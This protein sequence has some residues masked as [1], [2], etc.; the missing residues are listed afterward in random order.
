MSM[1]KAAACHHIKPPK[2]PPRSKTMRANKKGKCYTKH[3]PT[4]KDALFQPGSITA[5][6]ISVPFNSSSGPTRNIKKCQN[7][8]YL[9]SWAP[10]LRFVSYSS[11]SFLRNPSSTKPC[12]RSATWS[13]SSFSSP[14]TSRREEKPE[15]RS[16]LSE[17]Q[18]H[19]GM[20]GDAPQRRGLPRWTTGGSSTSR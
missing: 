12:Q 7:Y 15:D 10:P 5:I 2:F 16:R 14:Y 3:P 4:K 9:Y 20:D 11:L 1:V 6:L 17:K 19:F 8:P 13:S 18:R